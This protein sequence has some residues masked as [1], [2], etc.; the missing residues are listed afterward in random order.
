[1]EI[2]EEINEGEGTFF[3][4]TNGKR[5]ARL[6]FSLLPDRLIIEH[7]IV[8]R[9]LEGKGIG[10]QLVDHAVGFARNKK[11]KIVPLCSFAKSVF[12]RFDGYDDVL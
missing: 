2:Q 8:G 12:E 4:E 10:K 3:I 1:M 5:T 11:I 7:T 9:E 6:T